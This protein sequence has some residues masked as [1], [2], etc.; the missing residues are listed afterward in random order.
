MPLTIG[1]DMTEISKRTK[2]RK[3]SRV[4]GVAGRNILYCVKLLEK[5]IVRMKYRSS[6]GCRMNYV[7]CGQQLPPQPKD[8]CIPGQR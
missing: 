1:V 7:A 3:R 2:A 5:E 4:S 8:G 6:S